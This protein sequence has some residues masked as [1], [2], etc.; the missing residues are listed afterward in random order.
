MQSICLLLLPA[1]FSHC[2]LNHLIVFVLEK[3]AASIHDTEEATAEAFKIIID[4][5]VSQHLS[6][7]FWY[8]MNSIGYKTK[9]GYV[10]LPFFPP[11]TNTAVVNRVVLRLCVKFKFSLGIERLVF[12]SIL[13]M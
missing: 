2:V 10:Y 4:E 8:M 11:T 5:K 13:F 7:G 1:L 12:T 6:K 3:M 9:W